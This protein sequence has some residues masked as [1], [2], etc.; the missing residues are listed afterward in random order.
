VRE[1]NEA[2]RISPKNRDA[3]I[4][5]GD[6]HLLLD[7]MDEAVKVLA[8]A[9]ACDPLHP[10]AHLQLGKV[11]IRRGWWDEAQVEM[12]KAQ[13]LKP[14]LSEIHFHLGQ[15][16]RS[17]SWW[18]EALKEFQLYLDTPT[19]DEEKGSQAIDWIRQ[20]QVWKAE[21]QISPSAGQSKLIK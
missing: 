17:K 9:V 20:I 21:L 13:E 2:I 8:K 15:I 7:R 10:E 3:L 1:F 11:Y 5:L 14:G 12:K 19:P 4:H 6:T 18:D 16:Y